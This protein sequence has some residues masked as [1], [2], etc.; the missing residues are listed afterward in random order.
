MFWPGVIFP[1]TFWQCDVGVLLLVL[2][3][4][5]I[6]DRS[7]YRILNNLQATPSVAELMVLNL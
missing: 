6:L 2:F 7:L 3:S 4:S 5:S 1:L